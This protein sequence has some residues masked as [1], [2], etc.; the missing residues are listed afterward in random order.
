M[1]YQNL[2]KEIIAELDENADPERL[3]WAKKNYATSMLLKGV[4]VPNIRPIVKDLNEK[5]KKEEAREVVDFAKQLNATRIFEAQQI[6]Y[7]V[8]DKHKAA[9]RS[10]MLEEIFELGEGIDNW[11]S[12]DCFAG[13]IAGPSWREGQISDEV[14]KGWAKSENK[15]WRRAA[16]VCTVALNQKARGGEGDPEKTLKICSLVADDQEDMVAKSLSWAL[17]ELAKRDSK[18]VVEFVNKNESVLPKRVVR[19]VRRKIE[20]GRKYN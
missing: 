19:E 14:I 13:Y 11:V 10:L 3:E 20:T 15:W 7:E 6:A 2:I 8:L 1:E 18:P 9:R 4:T 17:R 12:V 16:V 5:F